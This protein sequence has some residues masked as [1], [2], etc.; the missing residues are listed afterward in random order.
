[1]LY[2]FV[3]QKRNF[4]GN[5]TFR[6]FNPEYRDIVLYLGASFLGQRSMRKVLWYLE[7]LILSARF[8]QKI[9]INEKMKDS[10]AFPTRK[11]LWKYLKNRLKPGYIVFEFG[12]ASGTATK[13][14]ATTG[15]D[16][17]HWYGF[18]TF[19]GLP[20]DWTRG[21]I[22]VLNAGTFDQT[23]IFGTGFPKVE[24]TYE[25]T[26]IK[27]LI[28]DTFSDKFINNL[29]EN[30]FCIFIDV[31]LYKPSLHIL[32]ILSNYLK[33]GDLIYFDEAFDPWNEW[34][35]LD[36]TSEALPKFKSIAHTGSAMLIE[37]Q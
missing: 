4:A 32:K 27:G 29:G 36:E 5:L 8:M 34:K 17:K 25:I 1:M 7:T 21:G 22:S 10:K 35:A 19:T 12:V 2:D 16:F 24:A 37:I 28:E 14:W 33:K 20:E 6:K 26:W 15:V 13:F 3:M 23:L 18:D 31:D 30:N 9:K 11:R